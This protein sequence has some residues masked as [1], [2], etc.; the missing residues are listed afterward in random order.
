VPVTDNVAVAAGYRHPIHLGSCR[1]SFPAEQLHLFSP[2]GVTEVSPLPVLAA[3]EDIVQVRAPEARTATVAPRARPDLALALRV[4]AGGPSTGPTV[5]ALIPW[6]RVSWLQRLCY[7]LPASALRRYK[8]ASLERG[9]L[10]RAS[11]VLE[12][13]PFGTLF[14]LAAPDVLIPVGTRLTPAVSPA[15]LVERLGA[16]EGNTVVFPDRTSAPFRVPGAIM[17]PLELR[18]VGALTPAIADRAVDGLR[19][20]PIAEPVEIENRAMGPM[21]LWGLRRSTPEG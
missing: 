9:V 17:V 11:D 12:G 2:G 13:I 19:D 16:T 7:A 6:N 15:L 1:G 14:E 20:E 4:E 21:P 3:I 8:V 10:V 5:A 18:V